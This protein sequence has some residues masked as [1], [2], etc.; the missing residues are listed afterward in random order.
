MKKSKNKITIIL[1]AILAIILIVGIRIA[2]NDSGSGKIVS[3]SSK[4]ELVKIYDKGYGYNNADLPDVIRYLLEFTVLPYSIFS[5]DEPIYNNRYYETSD[6]KSPTDVTIPSA[7][8]ISGGAVSSNSFDLGFIETKSREYSNTNLQVK[9]V[10]E[11]DI[12]KT[13]GKYIYSI[14]DNNVL[15]TDV[16]NPEKMEVVGVIGGSDKEIP[17]DLILNTDKHC[18]VVI[19]ESGNSNSNTYVSIYNISNIKEIKTE[20][21]FELK[22]NYYTS[23]AVNGYIYII[24]TGSLR[25]KDQNDKNDKEIDISY[26]EDNE[27]KEID[28]RNIQYLKGEE[29]AYQTLVASY[30]L[31]STEPINVNSYLF[32][33]ENVYVS[34]NNIYIADSSY[35]DSDEDTIGNS[36]KHLFG[37][38]GLLGWLHYEI[39]GSNNYTYTNKTNINKIAINE[40]G[41]TNYID[42][43]K[44][45]GKTINQFSMDEYNNEFRIALY[46]SGKGSRIVVFDENLKQIGETEYIEPTENMYASRFIG[47]RAYLVTYRNMDPL[48]VFD[49]SNGENPKLLGKLE[50]PGYSTYLQ[51]YDEDHLIGIGMNS[52]TKINKDSMGRVISSSTVITGMKMAIFDVSDVK[53]PKQISQTTIGDRYTTSAVLDNHKALLFSKAKGIICIPVNTYDTRMEVTDST[54]ISTIIN[55]YKSYNSRYKNMSEGYLVYN[56]NLDEGF[57]LKGNITHEL[58]TSDPNSNYSKSDLLRGLWIEDYLFTISQS[59]MKANRISDLKLF[60]A[61][62]LH[63]YKHVAVQNNDNNDDKK[64]NNDSSNTVSNDVTNSVNNTVVVTNEI[65]G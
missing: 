4:K 42:S 52:E 31:G 8:S 51:A 6:I 55:D 59:E 5:F 58:S 21:T 1:F 3:V 16:S 2:L 63:T 65:E 38:G 44:V 25:Q 7:S 27:Y 10:D 54:N 22:S 33:A 32:S 61:L 37:P 43:A 45:N 30:K 17:V 62:N 12:T 28:L 9:N 34:E 41:K 14:S 26:T 20:K 40:E 56:I 24:S 18:L 50:I 13:D 49:L 47:N 57:K 48:F 23:R 53:N 15:I 36:F 19:K 11:A 60:D 39:E 35:D 46:E 29:S 64:E